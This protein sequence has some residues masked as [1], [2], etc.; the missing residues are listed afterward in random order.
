MTALDLLRKELEAG[1]SFKDTDKI[2]LQYGK[3]VMLKQADLDE[4]YKMTGAEIK[5][6]IDDT[7]KFS[8]RI[9]SYLERQAFK[10]AQTLIEHPKKSA[11]WLRDNVEWLKNVSIFGI[12]QFAW[13]GEK[14]GWIDADT[15]AD[16]STL[17]YYTT[18]KGVKAV[19]DVYLD[20]K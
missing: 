17:L 11:E 5:A 8:R 1:S 9:M 15:D 14:K 16:G 2:L 20:E 12:D 19:K 4:F 18:P 6:A 3:S 13:T 7:P 10:L